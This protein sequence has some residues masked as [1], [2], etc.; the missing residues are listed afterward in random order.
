MVGS[1][2]YLKLQLQC[3][4]GSLIHF[5]LLRILVISLLK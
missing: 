3:G 4:N 2:S 1:Y 5:S